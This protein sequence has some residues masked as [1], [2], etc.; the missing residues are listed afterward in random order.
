MRTG[1]PTSLQSLIL[2]FTMTHDTFGRS[3]LD[4]I[5][6]LTNT[7][8]SDDTPKPDGALKNTLRSKILHYHRLYLDHPDPLEIVFLP[9][10]VST[11]NRLYDDFIRFLFL[12]T[13]RETRDI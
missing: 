1:Q 11:S 10:S 13:H 2:D 5:G 8:Q 12:Y 3:H 4:H 6:Q 7:T 9:S